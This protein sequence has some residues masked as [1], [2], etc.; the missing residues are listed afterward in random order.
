VSVVC[1]GATVDVTT[2]VVPELEVGLDAPV[3]GVVPEVVG[4]KL[5][6]VDNE[7]PERASVVGDALLGGVAD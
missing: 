2:E 7:V 1:V 5:T 6:G 4:A 3:V